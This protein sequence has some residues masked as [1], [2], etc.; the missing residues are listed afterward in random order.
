MTNH[1]PM[2]TARIR[3]YGRNGISMRSYIY[4][5][6]M[7]V[8][9]VR[10]P[11]IPYYYIVYIVTGKLKERL[12]SYWRG[13]IKTIPETGVNRSGGLKPIV[14]RVRVCETFRLWWLAGSVFHRLRVSFK[15]HRSYSVSLFLSAH[16]FLLLLLLVPSLPPPYHRR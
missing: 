6:I 5:I 11:F 15:D 9:D 14:V 3:P 12:S 2:A 16:L 13:A 8:Y 7:Y 4:I 10:C 1:T